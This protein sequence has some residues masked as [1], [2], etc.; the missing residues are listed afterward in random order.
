[1]SSDSW[2]RTHV[3]TRP[4]HSCRHLCIPAHTR[5]HPCTP[6][7][8]CAHPCIP[9]QSCVPQFTFQHTHSHTPVHTRKDLTH[10]RCR[11]WPELN[12]FISNQSKQKNGGRQKERQK[13][14]GRNKSLLRQSASSNRA[15]LKNSGEVWDKAK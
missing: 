10:T 4:P 11:S 6:A 1:M 14:E 7:H 5:T 13:K 12:K 2:A 9:A 15:A 3:H 8:T